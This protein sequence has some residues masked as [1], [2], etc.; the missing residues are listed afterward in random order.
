MNNTS[1]SK[2]IDVVSKLDSN[3]TAYRTDDC[4]PFDTTTPETIKKFVSEELGELDFLEDG[5]A[6][7]GLDFNAFLE[8][9]HL[10]DL[11][12][13]LQKARADV[14][15]QRHDPNAKPFI[16]S[17]LKAIVTL[18]K[19]AGNSLWRAYMP[20]FDTRAALTYE[21][22]PVWIQD[23]YYNTPCTN[24][25]HHAAMN[26]NL[27]DVKATAGGKRS[28]RKRTKKRRTKGG[29]KSRKQR[30]RT[31]LKGGKRK[32]RRTRRRR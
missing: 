6:D 7:V 29:K 21:G 2:F 8:F 9:E 26:G 14:E 16:D 19:H 5:E 23:L 1:I 13:A 24:P 12:E 15:L 25:L 32:R 18:K 17:L 4:K 31:T 30:K 27:E 10:E 3:Q 22:V 11:G 28:R 20:G